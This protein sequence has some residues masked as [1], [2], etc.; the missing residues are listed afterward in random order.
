M[1]KNSVKLTDAEWTV[2]NALWERSPA[3][4]RD[5]LGA[6]GRETRWAYTTLCTLLA[7]LADKGAVR[8]RKEKNTIIYAPKVTRDEA[9]RTAVRSLLERAFGGTKSPL[10]QQLFA[11]E[12]LSKEERERLD[13]LIS[14]LEKRGSGS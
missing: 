7:R 5:L 8:A 11:E 6:V 10:V 4:A 2:M 3:S 9:R 13:D 1:S 12:K 14:G